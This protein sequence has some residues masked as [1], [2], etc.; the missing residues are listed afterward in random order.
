MTE[1]PWTT[2]GYKIVDG[3]WEYFSEKKYPDAL[4]LS[5]QSAIRLQHSVDALRDTVQEH[6][7]IIAG[8]FAE[9][10]TERLQDALEGY[11]DGLAVEKETARLILYYVL[12]GRVDGDEE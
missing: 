6:E 4:E 1:Y 8:S 11:C 12:T 10:H 5:Q 7:A 3:K 9:I 2:C